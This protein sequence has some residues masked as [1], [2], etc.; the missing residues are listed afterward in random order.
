MISLF[1]KTIKPAFGGKA[2]IILSDT[3]SYVLCV[4]SPSVDAAISVLMP[5]MDTSNYPK[6]HPL[7]SAERARVPGLLKNE[8]PEHDLQRC[9]G[10]RSK[11]YAIKSKKTF[12][13]RCKGVK[14]NVRKKIPFEEFQETVLGPPKT[15]TVTQHLIQSKNHVNRLVKVTKTAMTSFDD[16]RSLASCGIHSFPY[17]S[18]LINLSEEIG[19]CFYCANPKLF[20]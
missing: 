6:Q 9:V 13:S 2:T 3:D 1:Y 11:V 12:D 16:K 18:K 10:V 5:V 14:T 7:Y 17:G 19:Q 4:G 20:S 15:V 8:S